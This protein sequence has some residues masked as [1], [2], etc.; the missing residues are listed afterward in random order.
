[1]MLKNSDMGTQ[2]GHA[3]SSGYRI[4]GIKESPVTPVAV[5]PV[6]NYYTITVI[7]AN[8]LPKSCWNK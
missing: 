8:H 5:G 3:P 6:V 2:K 7:T 1:M 4:P